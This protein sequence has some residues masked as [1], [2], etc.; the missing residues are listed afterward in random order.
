MTAPQRAQRLVGVPGIGLRTPDGREWLRWGNSHRWNPETLDFPTRPGWI[1][2][3]CGHP[4]GG[5]PL[6]ET[7]AAYELGLRYTVCADCEALP[8]QRFT[9]QSCAYPSQ[10]CNP[11]VAERIP[12]EPNGLW[13]VRQR[14]FGDWIEIPMTRDAAME[15]AVN[16]FAEWVVP[17][18]K[19]AD[20]DELAWPR[21]FSCF[22]PPDK[23]C[24]VDAIIAEGRRRGVWP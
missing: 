6:T 1:V 2:A 13:R 17:K 23:P 18:W 21:Y 14:V 3:R 19:T 10:Y 16:V 24:H 4:G 7:D 20:L 15:A 12:N 11:W 8:T 22:C 9:A 5:Q